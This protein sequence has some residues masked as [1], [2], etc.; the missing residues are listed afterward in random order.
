MIR[1]GVTVSPETADR[2][3]VLAGGVMILPAVEPGSGPFPGRAMRWTGMA[4]TEGQRMVALGLYL[5]LMTDT[6][7]RLIGARGPVIVEGPFARNPDY[8]AMLAA[9]RPEGVR[10]AASATGTSVGAA[11]LLMPE[12]APP[13]TRTVQ[14]PEDAA[15][16]QAYAAHWQAMV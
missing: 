15:A 1:N 9:L 10:I 4:E 13:A 8:L 11:L 14:A 6:C 5:A 12:A 2:N 3:A 7:L 16:L